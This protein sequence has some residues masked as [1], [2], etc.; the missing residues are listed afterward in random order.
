MKKLVIV[1]L[2]AVLALMAVEPVHAQDQ[3]VL[4]IIDTA[5]DSNKIPSVI[6]E[7]CFA[8]SSPMGCPSGK[9]LADSL[10]KYSFYEGKGAGSSP[11]W[12]ATQINNLGQVYHG[13]NATQAALAINPEIKIVF[14]RMTGIAKTN[15][16]QAA[17][18]KDPYSIVRALQWVSDNADKYSIDAVSISQSFITAK[19]LELCSN[20]IA[21]AP[22]ASL[23]SKNIP[24]FAATGNNKLRDKVGFPACIPGVTGVGAFSTSLNILD[25]ATNSGPGLDVIAQD[26]VKVV[27][28]NGTIA[29]FS[30]SSAAT[31]I[32]ASVFLSKNTYTTFELFLN[33]FTKV[34]GYTY[35]SK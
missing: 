35:I 20:K 26:I 9:T 19:S 27:R 13:Y 22:V 31:Q 33:S 2:S 23:G 4:A 18:P 3:K 11:I 1:A 28:H 16:M 30:A 32:A 34:L 24:V 7:V 10:G 21:V 6:H 8:I 25:P 12:P 17:D 15:G 29:N 14:I 5:V